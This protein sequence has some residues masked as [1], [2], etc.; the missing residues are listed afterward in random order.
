MPSATSSPPSRPD[1]PAAV[2]ADAGLRALV[3]AAPHAAARFDR[4][5]RLAYLNPAARAL[6]GADAAWIGRPLAELAGRHSALAAWEPAVRA[7][8]ERGEAGALRTEA[9]DGCAVLRA[10]VAAQRGPGGEAAGALL[11]VDEA[12]E[13]GGDAGARHPCRDALSG[14]LDRASFLRCLEEAC[15]A[16]A[17]SGAPFAVLFVDLDRFKLLNDRFGHAFGDAVLGIVGAR[18]LAAVRPGDRVGRLGGDEFAVLLHGVAEVE[19]AVGAVQRIQ[20][21][22]ARPMDVDGTAASVTASVGLAL[23]TEIGDPRALLAGADRAMYYAKGLGDGQYQVL[24]STAAAFEAACDAVGEALQR[25]VRQGE[26]AVRYQPI[27]SLADGRLVGLE[28]LVRWNHPERGLLGPQAFLPVAERSGGI[29][30]VDRWVLAHV[31]GQLRRWTDALPAGALVPVSVNLS[32]RHPDWPNACDHV[33]TLLEEHGVGAEWLVVEI[34]ETALLD[35]GAETVSALARLSRRGV[36]VCLD[37]FGTGF[38]SL[39]HLRRLAIDLLKVDRSFVQRIVSDAA[40]RAI[41]GSVVQLAHA[42]GMRVVAEGIE[43][44]SQARALRALGCHQGQ[45]WLYGRPV[46]AAEI[47]ALLRAR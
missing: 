23:A 41:V 9:G 15:G 42:L 20:R 29:R 1:A 26:L 25:A 8:L 40:D 7:A 17:A 11:W 34:T 3:D 13:H 12:P 36:R 27:V 38:S 28:A 31:A 44:E 5:G 33:A 18:L 10:R 14:T 39:S 47:E 37:H 4:E 2:S 43:T 46:P 45:G 32:P 16:H 21:H 24:D 22:L 35:L 19:R 6:L 30:E